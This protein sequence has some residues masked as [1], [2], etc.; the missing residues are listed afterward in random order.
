MLQEAALLPV[1]GTGENK[2]RHRQGQGSQHQCKDHI[3]NYVTIVHG[4]RS[5]SRMC[6]SLALRGSS[7]QSSTALQVY[8]LRGHVITVS[9]KELQKLCRPESPISS[10]LSAAALHFSEKCQGESQTPVNTVSQVQSWSD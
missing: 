10:L 6:P 1:V 4:V 5:C 3:T 8:L 2:G 7:L 9:F